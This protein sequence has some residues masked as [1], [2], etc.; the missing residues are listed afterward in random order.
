[1]FAWTARRSTRAR[2]FLPVIAMLGAAGVRVGL[3]GRMLTD[4][5]I[6]ANIGAGMMVLF[7]GPTILALLV[8]AAIRSLDLARASLERG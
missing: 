2:R 1:M 3:T 4:G 8:F 7:G 6:G 5:V